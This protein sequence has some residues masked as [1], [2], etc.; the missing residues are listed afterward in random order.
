MFILSVG[1]PRH[2]SSS[3]SINPKLPAAAAAESTTKTRAPSPLALTWRKFFGQRC[4]HR[5]GVKENDRGGHSS[6]NSG[7]LNPRSRRRPFLFH[8]HSRRCCCCCRVRTCCWY[9]SFTE[10]GQEP[11]KQRTNT[12]LHLCFWDKRGTGRAIVSERVQM[13]RTGLNL[14]GKGGAAQLRLA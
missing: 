13:K 1:R 10:E 9:K 7:A 14:E 11:H 4:W 3:S 5:C 8:A 2:R 6:S 12:V